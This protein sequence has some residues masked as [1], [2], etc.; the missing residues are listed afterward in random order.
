[1][2]PTP[3]RESPASRKRERGDG[4]PAGAGR[5]KK[6][7]GKTTESEEE[8][9]TSNLLLKHGDAILAIDM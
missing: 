5:G 7:R 2:G 1:V 4:C 9:A 3:P 8:Y 6:Y